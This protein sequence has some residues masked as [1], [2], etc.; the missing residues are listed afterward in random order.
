MRSTGSTWSRSSRVLVAASALSALL[1]AEA[2]ADEKTDCATAH[3]QGQV[4]RRA[5]HFDRA[6]EA[7]AACQADACPTVVRTRCA[8]FARE[9]ESSQP[10]A[11]IVVFEERG[12]ALGNATIGIDGAPPGPVPAMAL[13]L[14]PGAHTVHAEAPGF[15]PADQPVTLPEGFKNMQVVVKL[16]RPGA[17]VVAPAPGPQLTSA[18]P[19]AGVPPPPETPPPSPPQSGSDVGAWAFAIGGG[20]ALAGAATLSAVGWATHESLK[21]SCGS[22]PAGCTSSQVSSL[23]VIWPASFVAL[24][25]GVASAVVATILFA[26]HSKTRSP[27]PTTALLLGPAGA[28]FIFP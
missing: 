5:G 14:D 27:Q 18:P 26:N 3:E 2:R 9:L 20:V 6:R 16:S 24:G 23:Q 21:S 12:G 4:A 11:V 17:P 19:V 1:P 7:F 15:V 10:S 25:V 22:T 28:E 8:E 13:R